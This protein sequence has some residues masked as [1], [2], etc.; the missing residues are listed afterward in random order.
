MVLGQL[1][2]DN[3][4]RIT[5]PGTIGG[6]YPAGNYPGGNYPGGNCP[7]PFKH[8]ILCLDHVK[9]FF[10]FFAISFVKVIKTR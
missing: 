10:I 7:V 2:P 4:P 3:C 9:Y 8:N 5:G 6:N 1:P